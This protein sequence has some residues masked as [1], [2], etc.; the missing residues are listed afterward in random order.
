MMNHYIQLCI[1]LEYSLHQLDGL[2]AAQR[3]AILRQSRS[4]HIDVGIEPTMIGDFMTLYTYPD[5]WDKDG[6]DGM[7]QF[8]HLSRPDQ[9]EPP[10]KFSA[11]DMVIWSHARADADEDGDHEC[12]VAVVQFV[13][14]FKQCITCPFVVDEEA[15]GQARRNMPFTMGSA[16]TGKSFDKPLSVATCFE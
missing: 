11:N 3:R 1:A 16:I 9:W 12:A 4:V 8:H 7:L 6:M 14:N 2:P 15:L 10:R 13:N 5:S